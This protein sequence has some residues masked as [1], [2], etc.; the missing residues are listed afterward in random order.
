MY[1]GTWLKSRDG[2]VSRDKQ[3]HESFLPD[4]LKPSDNYQCLRIIF[5]DTRWKKGRWFTM[6]KYSFVYYVF[7]SV[8]LVS[9]I[10]VNR[11]F[12]VHVNILYDCAAVRYAQWTHEWLIWNGINSLNVSSWHFSCSIFHVSLLPFTYISSVRFVNKCSTA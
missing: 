4:F 12:L 9:N 1:W 11:I 7:T 10:N 8:Q 3:L 6:E 2:Q 5:S